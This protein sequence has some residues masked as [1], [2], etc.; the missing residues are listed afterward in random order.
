MVRPWW[1]PLLILFIF[2]SL[3]LVFHFRKRLKGQSR[4]RQLILSKSLI[5]N[6][7]LQQFSISIQCFSFFYFSISSLISRAECCWSRV[8]G[9]IIL[10][11]VC[12][13]AVCC[14]SPF[15]SPSSPRPLPAWALLVKM[16]LYNIFLIKQVLRKLIKPVI[17][18][19]LWKYDW[20]WWLYETQM[21]KC[22]TTWTLNDHLK[23]FSITT[24]DSS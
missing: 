18:S 9:P 15:A 3:N 16:E 24:T 21:D 10:S 19:Q 23:V 22:H 5:I 14:W 8:A 7:P 11:S 2:I 17:R 12:S 4:V 20:F 6:N 13:Y 1:K